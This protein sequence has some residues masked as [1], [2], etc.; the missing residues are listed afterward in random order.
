MFDISKDLLA[1]VLI[2][3]LL[4]NDLRVVIDLVVDAYSLIGSILM[5]EAKLFSPVVEIIAMDCID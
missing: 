3:D 5:V 4:N 2:F 1:L